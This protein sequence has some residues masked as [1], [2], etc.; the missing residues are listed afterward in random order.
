MDSIFLLHDNKT[1]M[2][3]TVSFPTTGTTTCEAPLL[4]SENV[5][6]NFLIDD[7]A[8]LLFNK[9]IESQGLKCDSEE[10]LKVIRRKTVD[11]MKDE[12]L[13][14]TFNPLE[15]CG[16]KSKF[17]CTAYLFPVWI[18]IMLFCVFLKLQLQLLLFES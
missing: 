4:F 7:S 16:S 8:R 17:L 18:H 6:Q 11:V 1:K 13:H 15:L 10:F 9:H 12:R 14:L 2:C 5:L 3:N